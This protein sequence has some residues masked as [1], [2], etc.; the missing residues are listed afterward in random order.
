MICAASP[1]PLALA[2]C[3]TV[4]GLILVNFYELCRTARRARARR[5]IRNSIEHERPIS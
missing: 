1:D 3:L 2:A 4:A 5:E